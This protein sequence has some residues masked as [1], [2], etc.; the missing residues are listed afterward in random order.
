MLNR[1]RFEK[2]A[3][4]IVKE[5]YGGD[6]NQ[7]IAKEA[8]DMGLSP[9][10]VRSLLHMVN[11]IASLA[12]LDEAPDEGSAFA[13]AE[14]KKVLRIIYNVDDGG[15]SACGCKEASVTDRPKTK[16]L[17]DYAAPSR[18]KTAS[19][20]DAALDAARAVVEAEALPKYAHTSE[21]YMNKRRLEGVVNHFKTKRAA[22]VDA[23]RTE[24]VRLSSEFTTLN[25]PDITVFEK[26]ACYL[27]G[28]SA[29]DILDALRKDLRMKTASYED[30][31]AARDTS[32]L[33]VDTSKRAHVKL[34]RVI[35]LEAI[36]NA[37]TEAISRLEE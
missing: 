25:A 18:V 23:F 10:S 27:H 12:H 1:A 22:V 21:E 2:I 8:M 16:D 14:P 35:E 4:R 5:N 32:T 17:S 15:D 37:Y 28:D 31:L 11:T 7:A 33:I 34:A 9:D 20:E 30:H 6:L 13:L 26:E 3:D 24:L 36:Y 19:L 29:V